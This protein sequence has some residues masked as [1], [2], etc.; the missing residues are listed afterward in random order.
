MDV[1]FA[2][3]NTTGKHICF[4][5]IIMSVMSETLVSWDITWNMNVL[6]WKTYTILTRFPDVTFTFSG[7]S[8]TSYHFYRWLVTLSFNLWL[9]AVLLA[10]MLRWI[11]F[12][13][14]WDTNMR[15]NLIWIKSFITYAYH[16]DII[17]FLLV[18]F[19]IN[20]YQKQICCY[21]L[22]FPTLGKLSILGQLYLKLGKFSIYKISSHG[23]QSVLSKIINM[24]NIKW[25]LE[26]NKYQRCKNNNETG[27]LIY[28]VLRLQGGSF[29]RQENR[30]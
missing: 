8:L 15:Y 29:T 12:I 17:L 11:S 30:G 10:N 20:K 27:E 19:T 24:Q 26:F 13:S 1:K 16:M 21:F 7:E 22:L 25:L 6:Q 14:D 3:Y 28:T 9:P 2:I 5:A 4:P 18:R 23:S